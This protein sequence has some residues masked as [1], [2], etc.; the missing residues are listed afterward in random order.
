MSP[1]YSGAVGGKKGKYT[2][3]ICVYF[4]FGN[5]SLATLKRKGFIEIS[6]KPRRQ[7]IS[8]QGIVTYWGLVLD[9]VGGMLGIPVAVAREAL[10]RRS[11]DSWVLV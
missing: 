8:L 10:V 5:K 3:R 1:S 4:I 9:P 7:L 11:P 2:P 6:S